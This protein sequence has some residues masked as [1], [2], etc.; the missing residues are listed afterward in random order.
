MSSNQS[1]PSGS[2]ALG[3]RENFWGHEGS[4]E[5]ADRDPQ[6]HIEKPG[7]D[8][9][10]WIATSILYRAQGATVVCPECYTEY[11]LVN[12]LSEPSEYVPSSVLSEDDEAQLQLGSGLSPARRAYT[13][14][15]RHRYC[16]SC[17]LVAWGGVLL[18]RPQE[19]FV[20]IVCDV[21]RSPSCRP[22]R[23]SGSYRV[24]MRG[25]NGSGGTRR[26]SGGR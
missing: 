2:P 6:G 4:Y 20:E 13:D 23:R 10:Q 25:R 15:R 5:S 12:E 24:R 1:Q 18:D 22:P 9:L 3:S 16:P 17:G 21:S 8:K 11:E 14:H 19:L 26:T 7:T